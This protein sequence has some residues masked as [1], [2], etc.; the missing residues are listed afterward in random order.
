MRFSTIVRRIH[1]YFALALVP[2]M[3]M[4]ALSAFTMNHR[5]FFQKIYGG[6]MIRDVLDKEVDYTAVF[7]ENATPMEMA[8]Q[9]LDDI[10]LSGA[11]HANWLYENKGIF[12]NRDDPVKPRKITYTFEDNKLVIEKQIMRPTVYVERLHHRRGYL[13]KSFFDDAWGFL[14]DIVILSIIFWGISG[15]LMWW[16]LKNTRKAGM[17]VSLSGAGLFLFIIILL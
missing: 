16:K 11:F 4:Y 3:L 9:I 2:W 12:I 17:I 6:I 1:M 5:Q 14:V 7:P 10:D 8:E 13:Q 15:F